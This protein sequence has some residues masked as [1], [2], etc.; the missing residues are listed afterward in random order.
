MNK[1]AIVIGGLFLMAA[2]AALASINVNTATAEELATLDGVGDVKAQAIIDYREA[3]DG[4]DNLADLKNVDGIGTA[5]A[6]ALADD[7][8]FGSE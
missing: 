6:K 2:T 4:I 8:T 1:L 7:I 3:N 5:T